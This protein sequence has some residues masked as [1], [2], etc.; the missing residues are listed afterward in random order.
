[1]RCETFSWVN[2][3]SGKTCVKALTK[4]PWY[5]LNMAPDRRE[6][7]ECAVCMLIVALAFKSSGAKNCVENPLKIRNGD[8]LSPP[9][10]LHNLNP[11]H[12]LNICSYPLFLFLLTRTSNLTIL[13]APVQSHKAVAALCLQKCY[14]QYDVE[15]RKMKRK[16]F[17]VVISMDRNRKEWREVC[18]WRK[19]GLR[20]CLNVHEEEKIKRRTA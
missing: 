2:C 16:E 17:F 4:S 19:K 9:A 13:C 10:F 8:W 15:D 14:T 1:M 11:A 5:L 7:M 6:V 18:V 12:T 20:G 3:I